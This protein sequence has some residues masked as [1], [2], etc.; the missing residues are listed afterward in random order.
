MRLPEETVRCDVGDHLVRAEGDDWQVLRVEDFVALTR[1]VVL[2]RGEEPVDLTPEL[3][4]SVSPAHEGPHLLLTLYERRF[5]DKSDAVQAIADGTLG[6][7]VGAV[8]AV[9]RPLT[10]FPAATTDVVRSR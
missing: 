6:S 7:A 5:D 8:G 4:D 9:C 10:A 2:K 3:P 1:L